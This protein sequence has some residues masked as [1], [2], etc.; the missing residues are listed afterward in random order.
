MA[1]QADTAADRKHASFRTAP[2]PAPLETSTTSP[3]AIAKRSPG[4]AE[5]HERQ[6][7]R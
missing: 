2:Q 7:P 1:R 6:Q 3:A 4:L 5:G